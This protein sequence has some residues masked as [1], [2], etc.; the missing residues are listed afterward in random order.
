MGNSTYGNKSNRLSREKSPYLLQHAHNPVDWY[1]WGEA[2]FAKA[3][4]EN[5]PIFLSIGYSTCHW[6]HVMAHESFEDQE[7][8]AVLNAYYVAVKVDR[9]ERPDVDNVYMSAC[10]A[11]TGSGGWPLTIILTPEGKPFYAGTYLPKS[12]HW[13]ES[14]LLQVLD[15]VKKGWMDNRQELLAYAEKLTS[16]LRTSQARRPAEA[17]LSPDILYS[18]FAQLSRSFDKNYGGFGKAP[19]FPTPHNLLFLLSYYRRT[20]NEAALSM[21]KKT[22]D[23]M[24]AGG[25]YDHVGYGFA[26]YSVDEKWIV[27]HFEKMLYDN[28]LLAYVYL[29][30]AERTGEDEY[31][32][33]A[34]EILTYVIRDLAEPQGGFYSAED[35]DS[36]GGEGRFYTWSMSELVETLGAEKSAL[37]GG[38]YNVTEHGNFEQGVNILHTVGNSLANYAAKVKCSEAELVGNLEECRKKLFIRRS[39]RR[40]PFRDDKILTAWNALMTATLAKAAQVFDHAVYRVAAEKCLEFVMK[41][42]RRGDGRLMT[43]YCDGEARNKAYLDDYAYLLWALMELHDSSPALETLSN[44]VKLADEMINLFWDESEEGFFLAGKDGETL[45]VRPR[46]WVDAA[47]PSGNSVAARMLVRLSDKSGQEKYREISRRMLRRMAG[48]LSRSPMAYTYLLVAY[49]ELFPN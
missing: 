42:L 41:H 1:P 12:G 6:C 44:A 15:S 23:S 32:L 25:I 19:K 28:A 14:G 48:E 2:A 21:V 43:A 27:P 8:A 18:G 35:A 30:A 7:V 22:L 37:F 33:V 24:R 45:P 5:K 38:Y 36:E 17:E 47:M 3:R 13:G 9:E 46:E 39:Q 34:E 11:A 4:A 49:D 20:K 40:R 29:E 10:Q 16:F 31:R 26:R